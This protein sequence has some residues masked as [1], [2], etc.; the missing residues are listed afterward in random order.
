LA[1]H[2]FLC[3]GKKKTG[4]VWGRAK[5]IKGR[6]ASKKRKKQI[7]KRKGDGDRTTTQIPGITHNQKR[8]GVEVMIDLDDSNPL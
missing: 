8:R 7:E 1:Q 5:R 6:K 4:Y 2:W 3:Q